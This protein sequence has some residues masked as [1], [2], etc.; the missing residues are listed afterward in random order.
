MDADN[1]RA[2]QEDK[3]TSYI[4]TDPAQLQCDNINA[5]CAHTYNNMYIAIDQ[6][7]VMPAGR[8]A[9]DEVI[10]VMCEVF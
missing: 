6:I 9:K 10:D 1:L 3:T 7:V 5:L 2:H 8:F 4:G